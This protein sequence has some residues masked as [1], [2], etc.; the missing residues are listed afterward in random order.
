ME[1]LP[2]HLVCILNFQHPRR[3]A[4]S[5]HETFKKKLQQEPGLISHCTKVIFCASSFLYYV[6]VKGINL[7]NY[8]RKSPAYIYLIDRASEG[9]MLFQS[10]NRKKEQDKDGSGRSRGGDTAQEAAVDSFCDSETSLQS[11][12]LG[13]RMSDLLANNSKGHT[14]TEGLIKCPVIVHKVEGR[15]K[16]SYFILG[17][18]YIR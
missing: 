16:K 10:P 1:P 3:E 6:S 5:Y 4:I 17:P 11:H 9:K 13:N 14:Q 12:S 7:S 15:Q 8:D 2:W 18:S